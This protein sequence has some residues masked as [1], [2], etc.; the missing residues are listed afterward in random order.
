MVR[1]KPKDS[2]SARLD[3]DL[4]VR[5]LSLFPDSERRTFIIL[6]SNSFQWLMFLTV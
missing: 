2:L 6:I 1:K 3:I 4:S 5:C